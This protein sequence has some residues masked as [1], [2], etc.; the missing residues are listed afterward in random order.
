MFIALQLIGCVLFLISLVFLLFYIKKYKDFSKKSNVNFYEGTIESVEING[1]IICNVRIE[2]T[3]ELV[4]I[5]NVDSSVAMNYIPEY[6]VTNDYDAIIGRKI[7]FSKDEN[8]KIECDIAYKKK[9]RICIMY[10][11]IGVLIMAVSFLFNEHIGHKINNYE[12]EMTT[13]ENSNSSNE[14]DNNVTDKNLKLNIQIKKGVPSNEVQNMI[15]EIKKMQYVKNAEQKQYTIYDTTSNNLIVISNIYVTLEDGTDN[16]KLNN[17]KYLIENN[18][19]YKEIIDSII[20]G[21]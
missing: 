10:L 3:N 11:I 1:G 16:D 19:T 21:L 9:I 4:K 17:V 20:T 2:N 8:G 18:K 7:K 14:V 15:D 13:I 12:K 5:N 6:G